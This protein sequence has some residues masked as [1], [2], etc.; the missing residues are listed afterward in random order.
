MLPNP[1]RFHGGRYF[2]GLLVCLGESGRLMI[3]L[4]RG[5]RDLQLTDG[6]V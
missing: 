4:G 6:A 5:D 2:C 3:Y 1:I